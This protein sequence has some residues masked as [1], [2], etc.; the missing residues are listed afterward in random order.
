MRPAAT[1]ALMEIDCENLL[2]FLVKEC[3]AVEYYTEKLVVWI[4]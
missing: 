1:I 3:Q 4:Y 2:Y